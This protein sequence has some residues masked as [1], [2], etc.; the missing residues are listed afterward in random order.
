MIAAS[1]A[2]EALAS[3][4]KAASTIDVVVTD[5]GLPDMAIDDLIEE[6][7][8]IRPI[9]GTVYVSGLPEDDPQIQ[10]LLR[11]ESAAYLRKPLDFEVLAR[12]IRERASGTTA[13]AEA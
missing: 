4:A 13:A 11:D 3:Y 12:T 10:E 9:R 2:T 6:L 1:T 8:R 7:N 5:I